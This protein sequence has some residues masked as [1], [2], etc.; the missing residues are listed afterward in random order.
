MVLLRQIFPYISIEIF[1][2]LLNSQKLSPAEKD[3]FNC[4]PMFYAKL[5]QDV[6]MNSLLFDYIIHK[7]KLLA[8]ERSSIWWI[9]MRTKPSFFYT[10]KWRIK[11]KFLP[12]FG[13]VS[14]TILLYKVKD[15]IIL[16][17]SKLRSEGLSFEDRPICIAFKSNRAFSYKHL[18]ELISG[19]RRQGVG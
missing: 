5:F 7:N 15:V 14:D 3:E 11:N 16:K 19:V 12:F 17:C 8:Q 6:G 9:K 4:S 2:Q 1:Q 13:S 18:V 10:I